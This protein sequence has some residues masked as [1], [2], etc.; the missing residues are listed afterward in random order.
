MFW[1]VLLKS[2]LG[3]V[4]PNKNEHLL[5]TKVALDQDGNVPFK[6]LTFDL[7]TMVIALSNPTHATPFHGTIGKKCMQ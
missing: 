4:G 2:V 6:S 7:C 5:H 1:R 3:A